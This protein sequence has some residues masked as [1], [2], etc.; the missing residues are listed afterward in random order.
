[1]QDPLV[2]YV[3]YLSNIRMNLEFKVLE[4]TK[5]VADLEAKQI[6]EPSPSDSRS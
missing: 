6:N 3:Q 1:M 4:L 5:K 2:E